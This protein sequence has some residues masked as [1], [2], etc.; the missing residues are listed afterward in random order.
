MNLDWQDIFV[1]VAVAWAVW[2]VVRAFRRTVDKARGAACEGGCGCTAAKT[3][4]D[5]PLVAIGP[6]PD[7]AKRKRSP[8]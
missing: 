3:A 2:R 7:G 4:N 1:V 5:L 6:A 8:S